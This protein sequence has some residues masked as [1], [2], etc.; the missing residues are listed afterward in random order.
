M[1]LVLFI[2]V[3]LMGLSLTYLSAYIL[4]ALTRPET[5]R[6]VNG[7]LNDHFDTLAIVIVIAALFIGLGYL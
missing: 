4:L 6:D 7:F 2:L 1:N 3:L 5:E